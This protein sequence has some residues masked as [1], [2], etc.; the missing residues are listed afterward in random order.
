MR[1]LGNGDVTAGGQIFKILKNWIH[2]RICHLGLQIFM[3]LVLIYLKI[4]ICD[5]GVLYAHIRGNLVD[6]AWDPFSGRCAKIFYTVF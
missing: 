4:Y 5:I 3:L 2:F 1:K 6:G